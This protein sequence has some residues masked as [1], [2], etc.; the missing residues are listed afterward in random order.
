MKEENIKLLREEFSYKKNVL[1]KYVAIKN[2]MYDLDTPEN[3]RKRKVFHH[4]SYEINF[5]LRHWTED[6]ENMKSILI[7]LSHDEAIFEYE[8]LSQ[9]FDE[10]EEQYPFCKRCIGPTVK[11]Y[12]IR[13]TPL[14]NDNCQHEVCTMVGLMSKDSEFVLYTDNPYVFNWKTK[15]VELCNKELLDREEYLC[16]YC[17][18]CDMEIPIVVL[19]EDVSKFE[20]TH[21]VIYGFR[22][23]YMQDEYYQLLQLYSTDEAYEIL[24]DK[25]ESRPEIMARKQKVK[26][27]IL[28]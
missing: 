25:I 14:K 6:Y 22:S 12:L 1:E 17:L 19:L 24:K 4:L 21:K 23:N 8:K 11:D 26:E 2:R 7:E 20:E 15:K 18:E 13:L 9:M 3:K 16:Y 28:R 27:R 5:P 10:M